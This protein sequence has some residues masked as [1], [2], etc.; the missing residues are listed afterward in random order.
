MV[1]YVFRNGSQISLFA[2]L[3]PLPVLERAAMAVVSAKRSKGWR[4][5][6][7]TS[8]SSQEQPAMAAGVTDRLWEVKDIVALIE[9]KEAAEAPKVRGPYKKR[10]QISN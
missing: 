9:A 1:R 10:A 3:P 7:T 6:A 2:D 5:V 4:K 8:P